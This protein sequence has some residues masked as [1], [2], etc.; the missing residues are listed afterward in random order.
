MSEKF[1]WGSTPLGVHVHGQG[2][3]VHV[4]GALAVAEQGGLHPLRPG[5]QAHLG[6]GHAGAP[7][8]VGVQGDDGA[9]PEGSLRMKY[10]S[11]S[12]N[13]LGMQFSTVV[14]R[15]RITLFSGVA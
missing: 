2:D 12:A 3:D 11:M 4:A 6:G 14:G 15:F 1:S 5:Q 8:V 13:W 10:S 9:V 7:V